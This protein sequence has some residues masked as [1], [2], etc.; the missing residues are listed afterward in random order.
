MDVTFEKTD[1]PGSY[2]IL[3]SITDHVHN[4]Y[5]KARE[6]FQLVSSTSDKS[7]AGN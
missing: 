3:V 4:T 5:A 7:K 2:T 1:L 6:Q